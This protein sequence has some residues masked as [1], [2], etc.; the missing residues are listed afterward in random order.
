MKAWM[1][2]LTVTLW[3]A[4]SACRT[5]IQETEAARRDGNEPVGIALDAIL[6]QRAGRGID[7]VEWFSGAVQDKDTKTG[8]PVGE[9]IPSFRAIDQNGVWQD[10]E[11]IRREKGAVLLFHRS[12]DW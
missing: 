5:E 2:M 1:A 3:C 6:Y 12:A 9:R 7:P 11:S 4:V 10:F 8:V